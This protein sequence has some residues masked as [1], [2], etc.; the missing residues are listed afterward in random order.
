MFTLLCQEMNDFV[1]LLAELLGLL[2]VRFQLGC[3]FPARGDAF[4]D[5]LNPIEILLQTSFLAPQISR[6]VKIECRRAG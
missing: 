2:M 5:I 1:N 4:C 6:S 3:G